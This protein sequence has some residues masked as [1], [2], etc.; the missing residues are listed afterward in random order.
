M[1]KSTAALFGAAGALM[2]L[3]LTFAVVMMLTIRGLM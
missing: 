1:R 3:A 2:A